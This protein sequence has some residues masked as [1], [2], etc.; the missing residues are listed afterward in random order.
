MTVQE[1]QE[2]MTGEEFCEWVEVF[3]MDKAA[4]EKARK[5]ARK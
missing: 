4:A 3:H 1:M 2:R 5:K